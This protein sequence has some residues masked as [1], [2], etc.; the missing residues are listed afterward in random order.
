[1]S[2]IHPHLRERSTIPA[3]QSLAPGGSAAARPILV[4]THHHLHRSS[5]PPLLKRTRE[6]SLDEEE[7]E[8]SPK[9]GG[10][11][12]SIGRGFSNE[13][14]GVDMLSFYERAHAGK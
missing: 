9:V 11:F 4:P 14:L 12:G 7:V 8:Q 10:Y 13:A 5:P 3:P 2:C 6:P 1:E